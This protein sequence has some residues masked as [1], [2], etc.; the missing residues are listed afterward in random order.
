MRTRAKLLHSYYTVAYVI[1][2]EN[3]VD[4]NAPHFAETLMGFMIRNALL[5]ET[6]SFI[7]ATNYVHISVQTFAILR[8]IY[9]GKIDII[10][11]RFTS[12]LLA[13]LSPNLAD[14]PHV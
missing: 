5:H 11:S 2:K 3:K 13:S 7:K 8:L 4:S 12:V 1:S 6:A 9:K 10:Q 14:E